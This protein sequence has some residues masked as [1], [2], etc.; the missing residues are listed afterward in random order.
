MKAAAQYPSRNKRRLSNALLLSVISF[1]IATAAHASTQIVLERGVQRDHSG[2]YSGVVDFAIEPG[3]DNAR[4][5]V[6]VDGQKV[7]GDLASPYHLAI[8]LGPNPIQ[9]R[10]AIT[11]KSPKGKRVQ[12]SETI[13]RGMLPL[14]VKIKAIDAANGVFE[15]ETTSPREDP[16]QSVDLWDNGRIIATATAAPYRFDVPQTILASG[17][18][19]ITAKAKSGEEAADFWSAAGNV[20]VEELQVRTVP[21]FV[22]IVDHHGNTRDDIDRS[23]F[24]VIDGESEAKIIEFGK[25]FDQPISIALL[26]DASSSMAYSMKHASKAASEFVQHALKEGDRCSITAVQDVPRR[27]QPLTGDRAAVAKAL[28]G[29]APQG[30]TALYDSVASAIRELRDEK[31]RRA[32][33][34][35]SDGSDTASNWSY[36]EIEK[37]AREAAIPIY[38][39]VY[40]GSDDE[41]VRNLDRLRFLSG[42]TGG[43]VATATQQNLTARY[44]AIEKDLRAQ[45][46]ITYQVSDLGRSNEW[47][48]VRV[49]VNSPQLSARTIKGY[50]TP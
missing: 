9:H 2:E 43:F 23:L 46:A 10:I 37:L 29:I 7:A 15:A 18:V 32:I 45:F 47:R 28:D 38:F 14:G 27:R 3:F 42:Q 5:T 31:N 36:D 49:V 17:F 25:A 8:D 22:S 30:R 13:N 21:I 48:P 40:E 24:R 1:F 33:V 16:I 19:Q 35:L 20:H 44:E 4:V 41:S 11:A 12:W 39:I 34:V 50:F 26:L 6:V